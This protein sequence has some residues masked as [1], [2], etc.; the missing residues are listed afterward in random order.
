MDRVK[1]LGMTVPANDNR[2]ENIVE[3][4]AKTGEGKDDLI[5]VIEKI[6]TTGKIRIN[7]LIP[8]SQG[9]IASYVHQNCEIIHQEHKEDGHFFDVIVDEEAM[10]RVEGYRV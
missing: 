5:Q 4:S 10:A 2:F 1:E 6:H 3:I 8:Y 9:N 7:I